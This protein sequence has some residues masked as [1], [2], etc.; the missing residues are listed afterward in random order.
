MTLKE[1][2]IPLV[3]VMSV[4][5]RDLLHKL[6]TYAFFTIK[7]ISFLLEQNMYLL[8]SLSSVFSNCVI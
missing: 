8:F 1:K 4:A 7:Q 5:F 3:I 6:T 2:A